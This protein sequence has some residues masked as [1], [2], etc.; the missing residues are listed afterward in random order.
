[1]PMFLDAHFWASKAASGPAAFALALPAG[2]QP[3][4]PPCQETWRSADAGP[5]NRRGRDVASL[6]EREAD[7]LASDRPDAA[8]RQRLAAASADGELSV[9][10]HGEAH[11]LGACMLSPQPELAPGLQLVLAIIT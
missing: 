8:K 6:L 9:A 4:K 7:S 5:A 1:M 2:L 11:G 10:V 3:I